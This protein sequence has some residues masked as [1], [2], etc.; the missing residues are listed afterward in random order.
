VD[1]EPPDPSLGKKSP[2]NGRGLVALR[3]LVTLRQ[4]F[5]QESLA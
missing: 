5:A 3:H 2:H 4:E 1:A